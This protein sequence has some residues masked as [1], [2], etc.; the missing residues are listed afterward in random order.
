MGGCVLS[1]HN[2]KTRELQLCVKIIY[3]RGHAALVHM[4]KTDHAQAPT[5]QMCSFWQRLN[6]KE[7]VTEKAEFIS[8][9]KQK[10]SSGG[11]AFSITNITARTRK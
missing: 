4:Q 11:F 2:R 6:N 9:P 1:E 7:M 3:E 10:L 5:S 8:K